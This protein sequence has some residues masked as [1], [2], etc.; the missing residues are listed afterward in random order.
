MRRDKQNKPTQSDIDSARD[1]L[2]RAGYA[3]ENLWCAQDVSYR[4]DCTEEQALEVA[5]TALQNAFIMGEINF[6]I[7]EVA[8][9]MN[10]KSKFN[11]PSL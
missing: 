5:N 7:D 11:T 6:I 9:A 2:R 1:V 8:Q 3:V 4:Y 10:L